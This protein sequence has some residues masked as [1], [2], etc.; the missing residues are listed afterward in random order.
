[1]PETNQ[2]KAD[3]SQEITVSIV[4][5]VPPGRDVE[6]EDF[7]EGITDEAERFPGFIGLRAF[8]PKRGGRNYRLVF[9]FDSRESLDRWL[10]SEERA[11]WIARADDL[12]SSPPR[13]TDITGTAQAKP[14]SLA[15]TPLEDF[16]RTSVSGIGLMLFGTVLA[17]ILANSRF[18]SD[19]EAFWNTYVTIGAENFGITATLRHWVN[20]ALMALFFFIVGLEIKR[21]ILV[22]ELRTPRNAVF[23]V[24]AALG[25]AVVPALVYL[26]LNFG[27]DYSHGWGVPIGTDTA[28]ALGIITLFSARVGPQLLVFLTAFAIID[29]ILAVGVIA[30]FYTDEIRWA[31][32]GVAAVLMLGLLLAN[33][34]G[35]HRWPTY[36]ILGIGVWIAVFESGVHG[37]MAGVL[38]AIVVPARSWI[39][40]GEFL[41]RGRSTLDDFEQAG[42]GDATVLSN[43]R[44]QHLV[45]RLERISEEV[46][47]PMTSIEHGLNPWVSMFVL[48]VFAFANA[49]IPIRDS[50]G[51]AVGSAVTW[52]VA[53]GLVIGKPI[54]ITLFAWLAIRFGWA[55]LPRAIAWRHVIGVALLGGVGFTMSLFITDLAF[56]DGPTAEL[57]RMGVLF[58]S[59]TAGL[60][61]YWLLNR[62]LDHPERD[63]PSE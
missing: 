2:G 54:G 63:S 52:G 46:L 24:A 50:M 49:G 25:G 53:A 61:G 56:E 43:E 58:G 31:A 9:W 44:Q 10:E 32:L 40:P 37:T 34:A 27:G 36:A 45:Q 33:L 38:V 28:F 41:R 11:I 3:R 14:L 17:L 29:D 22:G 48:P 23:P 5:Q 62:T 12:S 60:V 30:L 26:V 47:S 1:M 7:L 4:L 59:V 19:Y 15:L 13:A 57:A 55:V 6:F 16:V 51:D 18:S 20:D 39:N 35:F 8:R 21:E 42:S